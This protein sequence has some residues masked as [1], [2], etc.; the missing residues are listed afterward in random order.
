MKNVNWGNF[1][2][3][4]LTK[5]VFQALAV[6]GFMVLW[7]NVAHAAG[8]LP[9]EEPLQKIA[10]S[11]SGPVAKVVGVCSIILTGLALAFGEAGGIVKRVLQIVF[12]LTIAFTASSF[13]LGFFGLLFFFAFSLSFKGFS[14]S[15][16]LFVWPGN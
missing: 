3:D 11:L 9:W 8:D 10:A 1:K 12:G 16:C 14:F 2:R 4:I 5:E 6:M 7:S 13:F 15:Y